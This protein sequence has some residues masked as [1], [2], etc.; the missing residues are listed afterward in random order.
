M[1]E[2]PCRGDVFH[3]LYEVGPLVRYLEN[4]AYDTMEAVEKLN[5]QQ[6]RHRRRKGRKNLSLVQKLRHA[7]EAE[8]KAVTLAE[9]V[10]TLARWLQSDILSVAGPNYESRLRLLDFV[11]AELA[12]RKVF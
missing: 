4:R 1:P 5:R 7:Q 6:K 10:A 9:D 2:V 11:V 8:A 12:S 3:C